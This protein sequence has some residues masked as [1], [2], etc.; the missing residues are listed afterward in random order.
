V[1][2]RTDRCWLT[3]VT[4]RLP[5]TIQPAGAL[6]QALGRPD[7]WFEQ[8]AGIRQRRI[9]GEQDALMSAV[10]A[11]Q[12]CLTRSGLLPEEVG[13]LLVTSEAPPLLIGLAAA[14]HHRLELRPTTPTLEV[15]GACTGFLAALWLGHHLLPRTGA[16]LTVAVEA[17][18]RHLRLQPGTA[19]ETAALL[20]D[21]AA[22]AVL[23]PE[24]LTG[25]AVEL[26]GV[27]LGADGSGSD[28]LRVAPA[29]VGVEVLMNGPALA[30]RAVPILADGVRTICE[31][32]RIDLNELAGVIAHAGNGRM[33]AL[34]A[35]RLGLPA[36]MVHSLT[37]ENGNLGSASLPVA[38]AMRRPPPGAVAWTA[39][40]AGLTWAAALTRPYR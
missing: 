3:A 5:D 32:H 9:W 22:A 33:P 40:G 16:V 17:P 25:D 29:A 11:G 37:A 2:P 4:V 27:L 18:S 23:S 13:V 35:H 7:G 31:Q 39:V 28:L 34:L 36:E 24:P 10:E 15:G 21:A 19:G 14:L 26:L 8:H 12:E 38:W 6:D 1:L 30:L 20:G